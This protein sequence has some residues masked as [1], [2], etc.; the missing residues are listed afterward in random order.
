MKAQAKHVKE[1]GTNLTRKADQPHRHE[2]DRRPSSQIS[3][4]WSGILH[5]SSADVK[6]LKQKKWTQQNNSKIQHAKMVPDCSLTS[7]KSLPGQKQSP[8]KQ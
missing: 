2:E 6:N 5:L 8:K 3:I 1:E 7:S 4:S